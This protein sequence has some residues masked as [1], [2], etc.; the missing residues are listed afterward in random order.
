MFHHSSTAKLLFQY[1][2]A[3]PD[4]QTAMA[5]LCMP[6]KNPDIDDHKK[7]GRVMCYLRNTVDMPLTL[8]ANKL[9]VIKWWV[10]ALYAVHLDMRS[11]TGGTLSLGKSVIFGTST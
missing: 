3:Q 1:Q 11:H 7:L 2:R 6:V 10:D 9:Y 5:F 4:I 8:E